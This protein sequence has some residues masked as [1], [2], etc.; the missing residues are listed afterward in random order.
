MYI[1]YNHNNGGKTRDPY[2]S[3]KIQLSNSL[4]PLSTDVTVIGL[5]FVF[6]N[7]IIFY[8]FRYLNNA[9]CYRIGT[10]LLRRLK[11]NLKVI[12]I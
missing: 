6:L 2:P 7:K 12:I 3:L 9:A 5:H 4:R 1:S 10:L 11:F 8:I